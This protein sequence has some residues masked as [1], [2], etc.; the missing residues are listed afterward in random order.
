MSVRYNTDS[1]NIK[2]NF[3]TT[4][5]SCS[6]NFAN[7][8]RYSLKVCHK[9]FNNFAYYILHPSTYKIY[10]VLLVDMGVVMPIEKQTVNLSENATNQFRTEFERLKQD[11]ESS[12][13]LHYEEKIRLLMKQNEKIKQYWSQ[14]FGRLQAE[15]K[16]LLN[17]K[18]SK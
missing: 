16:A 2:C 5:F 8:Q 4:Y 10:K 14:S 13:A 17:S 18:L 3:C 7:V 9:C 1:D 15:Y 6:L 11:I 12:I